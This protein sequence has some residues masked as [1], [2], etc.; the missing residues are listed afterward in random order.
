MAQPVALYLRSSKDKHDVSVDAQRRELSEYV[1][2]QG[3]F[4]VE[5][6]ED[7]VE[8]AKTDDR[9]GFQAMISMSQKAA[10]TFNKIYCYDTS[11]FSRRQHHAQMYKHMLKKKGI[12]LVFL[13]LPKTDSILDPVV[14]SLMEIFDEFHSQKSK[15][16]G[17]RG[18]RENVKQGWRAGGSA[19][20]GYELDKV[21]V[22]SREGQPIHKSRLKPCPKH[23]S[24]MQA[25]LKGR[26]AG[27]GR[28]ELIRE[29]NI[30]KPMSTMLYAEDNLHVYAGHT[31]WNKTNE[32][33]DGEFVGGKRYRDRSEWIIHRDTHEPMIS[34]EEQEAIEQ[35]GRVYSN[36]KTR[37]RNSDYLLAG[38]IKCSCGAN[39]QGD[40]GYYRCGKRCGTKGVRKENIEQLVVD[41]IMESFLK[42]APVKQLKEIVVKEMR[43]NRKHLR[44][45]QEHLQESLRLTENEIKDLMKLAS[46]TTNPRPMLMRI[47][48]L[49]QE[50]LKT[51]ADLANV[52]TEEDPR[53]FNIDNKQLRT[54]ICDYAAKFCEGDTETLHKRKSLI[55]ALITEGTFDGFELTLKA[56][57]KPLDEVMMLS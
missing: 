45:K 35:Q 38:L 23:F 25:Y 30:K 37:T 51:E 50:R 54:W 52:E 2:E 20:Y 29:L 42:L 33:I 10:R 17:L 6:F 26:A 18:M 34:D 28:T 12:E 22:G 56:G 3:D 44:T 31:V 46:Q 24:T 14:E 27:R 8:S 43:A 39:Y 48:E 11:R 15:M 32:K 57:V 41:K 49:E 7:K 16:D 1:T 40:S 9:P 55:R 19:V 5:I 13:K 21:V 4:I 53:K 47:E 36:A